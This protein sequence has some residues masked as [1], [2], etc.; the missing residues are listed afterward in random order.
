MS[1]L[2]KVIRCDLIRLT[3]I[4]FDIILGM[5]WLMPHIPQFNVE[6]VELN[7]N[8]LMN[9]FLSEKVIIRCV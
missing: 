2:H 1:I 3:M 8:S 6:P 4:Y 9:L 5:G 7:F